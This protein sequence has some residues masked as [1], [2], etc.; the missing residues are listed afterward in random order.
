MEPQKAF[1][2]FLRHAYVERGLSEN[3]L[4]AYR[5][6]LQHYAIYLSEQ[7]IQDLG[8]VT[9]ETIAKFSAHLTAQNDHAASSVTRTISTVRNLHTFL[10]D[11]GLLT[12]NPAGRIRP[13]KLPKRL[14]K[15]ISIQEMQQLL[16]ATKGDSPSLMR[17][18][19][20][21]E[22]LYATGARISELVELSVDDLLENSLIR[23]RGKGDKQRL[24]PLGSFAK[25][26]LDTYMTRVRP[27]LAAKSTGRSHYL[28]FG[29]RGGKMT[30]QNAWLIIQQT[31]ERAKLG[32]DISPHTFRHSFA[33]HLLSGGADIRVVQELLGH[34]SISTTQIYTM[35]SQDFLQQVYQ[36]S[37]PRAR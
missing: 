11:E 5:R 26:A 23:V 3:T 22:L 4:T 19:A 36:T 17:D 31:A 21:L 9:Q 10:F 18:R 12:S 8:G 37:H 34:S 7:N 27:A 28:F 20:M 2:Q 25:K 16:D 1:E 15:A 30:R 6:D 35:V 13:P 24:I 29:V 32:V 14:P 33:T